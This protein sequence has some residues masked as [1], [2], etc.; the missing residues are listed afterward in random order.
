MTSGS[1]ISV[2][3]PVYNGAAYVG[4]A[5]DSVLAQQHHHALEIIVVDDGSG[6]DSA[7]VAAACSDRCGAVALRVERRTNGGP[8]AARNT[9]L[10]VAR[11]EVVAFLDADDLYLPEKFSLQRARLDAWPDRDIVIGRRQYMALDGG[12][13]ELPTGTQDHLALQLGCGLFRRSVFNRVGG[14]D[15]SFRICD[16]WDWFMRARELG[17]NLLLHDDLVLHQRLHGNNI[18]RDREQGARETMQVMRRSIE[19]RRSRGGDAATLAPLSS[20]N[21]EALTPLVSVIIPVHNGERY[22]GE[23][24]KSALIQDWRPL[25]IIVVDDGSSDG[26]AAVAASFGARVRVL[27]RTHEGLAATRNAGV[28]EAHGAFHLHLDA[29][30]VLT[31]GAI[32]ALMA[33]FIT[34]PSLEIVTG[35]FEQFA[36][37]DLE[38]T[39]RARFVVAS[40]AQRGHLANTSLMR[41]A[42]FARVGP[43]STAYR[44]GADMDW[45]MRADDAGARARLIARVVARRRIHGNNMSLTR[46]ADAALDRVRIVKAALDRRRAAR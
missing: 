44:T 8:A 4:D 17:V 1:S 20:F 41:A 13:A 30:D 24:I 10:A 6:D 31:A 23:A 9:G 5:I 38:E 14:F 11:G 2:I 25:E 26:S 34:D 21:E 36:S 37:P 3:I 39:I 32:S 27:S 22:L 42:M 7:A 12:V 43:I 35:Q 46:K 28:L 16:D 33:E 40:G 15:E 29:D 18:T 45:M 19:R